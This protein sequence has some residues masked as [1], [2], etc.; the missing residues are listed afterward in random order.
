MPLP[1]VLQMLHEGELGGP[2]PA[3]SIQAYLVAQTGMQLNNTVTLQGNQM[4]QLHNLAPP[5]GCKITT[6]LNPKP[7]VYPTPTQMVRVGGDV[8][9]I[10]GRCR[11]SSACRQPPTWGTLVFC[12][13][14]YPGTVSVFGPTQGYPE[15][16]PRVPGWA[17]RAGVGIPAAYLPG[18]MG[19]VWQG[20]WIGCWLCLGMPVKGT[21]PSPGCCFGHGA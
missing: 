19:R 17:G 15:P 21:P 2:T 1:T 12:C 20:V 14:G 6:P 7:E 4:S 16:S 5:I 13:R 9:E 8:P 18:C 11:G 10:G 3:H